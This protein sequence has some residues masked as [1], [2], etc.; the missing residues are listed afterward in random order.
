MTSASDL[1]A[2][3]ITGL[4]LV[5]LTEKVSLTS[6][7]ASFSTINSPHCVDMLLDD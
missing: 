6:R 3:M 4:A 1:P 2:V 7:A 5:K